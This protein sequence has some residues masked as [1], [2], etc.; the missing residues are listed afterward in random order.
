[1]TTTAAA[2]DMDGMLDEF[3]DLT[4]KPSLTFPPPLPP[5]HPFIFPPPPPPPSSS[6]SSSSSLSGYSYRPH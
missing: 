4:I 5:P 2:A 1:M 6:S 3:P